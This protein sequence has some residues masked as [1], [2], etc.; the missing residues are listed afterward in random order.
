MCFELRAGPPLWSKLKSYYRYWTEWFCCSQV[1][2]DFDDPLNFHLTT[3]QHL[4]L[5]VRVNSI[6]T[7]LTDKFP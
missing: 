4:L 6:N 1:R 2:N 5:W 7:L 3:P